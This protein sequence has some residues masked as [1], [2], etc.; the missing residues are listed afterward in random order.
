MKDI[1]LEANLTGIVVFNLADLELELKKVKDTRSNQGKIYPLSMVLVLYMLAKLSGM[2]KPSNI[3]SWIRNRKEQLLR[4]FDFQHDRLPCLN[5]IRDIF[6]GA[7]D[8]EQLE[9]VLTRYLHQKYGGQES[10][11]VTIDEFSVKTNVKSMFNC[12]KRY[13]YDAETDSV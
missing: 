13:K 1:I 5:T 6:S 10:R 11:L 7:F 3:A 8:V 4:F 12:N 9:E 2:D